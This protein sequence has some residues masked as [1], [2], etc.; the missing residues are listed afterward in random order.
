VFSGDSLARQVFNRLICWIRDQPLAFDHY[1]TLVGLYAFNETGDQFRLAQSDQDSKTEQDPREGGKEAYD[2]LMGTIE[3][4]EHAVFVF[5]QTRTNE[6]AK[7][8]VP[9]GSNTYGIVAG[10]IHND[11]EKFNLKWPRDDDNRD[12]DM[13]WKNTDRLNLDKMNDCGG[14]D[15]YYRRNTLQAT[16]NGYWTGG[17]AEGRALPLDRSDMTIFMKERGAEDDDGLKG[18]GYWHSEHSLGKRNA[19]WY[20]YDDAHFQC[21]LHKKWPD[22][23]GMFKFPLNGDCRDVM[24][25]NA[26]MALLNRVCDGK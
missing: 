15:H 2:E 3:K 25:L 19:S 17:H 11:F 13:T 18:W 24:N 26:G 4:E 14:A 20:G 8:H 9:E 16:I 6:A 10:L 22:K 21:G 1:Y 7:R 12:D 23:V 5:R